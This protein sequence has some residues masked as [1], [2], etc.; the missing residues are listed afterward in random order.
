MPGTLAIA[1]HGGAQN[2]SKNEINP[3]QEYQY[4]LG[5][6]EA[7][8]SG[9]DILEMGGSSL[10]AVETAVRSL[11]DNPLFNAGKGSALSSAGEAE[12]DAAI[13]C[14][15]TLKAGAVGAVKHVRNP[16]SLARIIMDNEK[17]TFL[18]GG[19]AEDVA[20]KYKLEIVTND[21]FITEERLSSLRMMKE[22]AVHDTVGAVALDMEGNLASATSTG[23]LT[24][25]LP[26]RIGDSPIIGSGTYANNECCAVS[27]TGEGDLMLRG[28]YAYNIYA[29]MRFKN[30]DLSEAMKAVFTINK[31][32]LQAEMGIVGVDKRGR[33]ML[34]S[35]TMP[36][37]RAMKRK[38]EK[39]FIGVWE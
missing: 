34:K 24:N 8:I 9:W 21:Y 20:R 31:K 16:V 3:D 28:V 11:E 15:K 38:Y 39:M 12:M 22:E 19:G 33:I 25:K 35:N 14:G 37:F 27:C 32:T 6:E 13:M 18:S 36:M 7:I 30:Y 1:V 29:L 26:G 23:G 10:D 2:R 5:L 17:Y 4:R